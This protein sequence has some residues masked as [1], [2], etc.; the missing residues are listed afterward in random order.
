MHI[1]RVRDFSTT[2]LATD[3]QLCSID[4]RDARVNA[5]F[6]CGNEQIYCFKRAGRFQM[7]S[8]EGKSGIV[9][10]FRNLK[11]SNNFFKL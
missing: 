8:H 6:F 1:V 9:I 10:S 3:F 5:K 4:L 11:F 7:M 2:L